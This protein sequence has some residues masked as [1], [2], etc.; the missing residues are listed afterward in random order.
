MRDQEQRIKLEDCVHRKLYLLDARNLKI[1]VYDAGSQVFIG[2]RTKFGSRFL[3]R[4]FHW[5]APM[6]AT[7]CPMK[8]I[9]ELP[10]ELTPVVYFPG[11]QCGNCKALVEFR[12]FDETDPIIR[13]AWHHLADTDC[14]EVRP[15]A[16]NNIELFNWLEKQENDTA[17]ES[18]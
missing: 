9:G 1:G 13:G 12:R 11:T 7:C 14:V 15:Y 3:D 17:P 5:D 6:N 8:V 18:G 2:I 10:E 4:E 16:I